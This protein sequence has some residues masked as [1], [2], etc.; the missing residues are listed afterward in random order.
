MME[1]APT[2]AREIAQKFATDSQ[3]KL[4]KIKHVYQGQF[5]IY[6]R[7]SNTPYIKKVRVVTTM[8]Y[9]LVD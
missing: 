4:G 1:E 5:S 8:E 3:S 2:K 9:Y 6:D 7:D